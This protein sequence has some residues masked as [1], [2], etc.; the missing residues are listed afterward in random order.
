RARRPTQLKC[1]TSNCATSAAWS[2]GGTARRRRLGQ[3]WTGHGRV[4]RTRGSIATGNVRSPQ[5]LRMP[6]IRFDATLST[7]D[8]SIILRL[9]GKVSGKL[10]SRG[11]VA[12]KGT[13]NGH[14]FQT[15]LE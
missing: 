10:P 8:K 6:A 7:I 5:A 3:T 11:Q 15:V 4:S 13:I 1:V 9:P 12:V 14:R 2:A